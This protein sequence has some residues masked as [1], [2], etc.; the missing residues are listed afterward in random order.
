MKSKANIFTVPNLLSLVRLCLIPV[1]VLLYIVKC[2]YLGALLV[3][4]LSALTD[5]A[6]GLIARKFHVV[7]D[8]GKMLDPLADKLTQIAALACLAS[9]FVHMRVVLILLVIKEV[10]TGVMSLISIHKSS[11]VYGALW[12]GKLA[13]ASLYTMAAIHMI[14]FGIPVWLS[15]ILMGICIALMTL[16]FLLY[17]KRNLRLI[18]DPS[19][20]TD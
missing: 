6:D 11:R 10:T 3:L 14:W 5:I 18:K 9:R 15:D 1:L 8:L 19:E 17:G 2:D 12:H 4:A 20:Q 16:S 13:T 7:S